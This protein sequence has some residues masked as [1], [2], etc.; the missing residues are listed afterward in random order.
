VT[1]IPLLCV[2]CRVSYAPETV[3]VNVVNGL[4][5]ELDVQML[6]EEEQTK[7]LL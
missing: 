6:E 2:W 3:V 4:T 7:K 1:H 5:L